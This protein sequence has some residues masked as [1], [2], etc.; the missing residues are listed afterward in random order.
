MS[1]SI[2]HITCPHCGK[3]IAMRV[4]RAL[5]KGRDWESVDWSRPTTEIARK[6]RSSV[7]TVS[8]MR[9][10]YAPETMERR[11]PT[12]T[13][14]WAAV[15]WRRPTA[16]LAASLRMADSYVSTMRRRYAPETVRPQARV[17]LY[18]DVDWERPLKVIAAELGITK[19]GAYLA[20]QRVRKYRE[21]QKR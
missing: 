15:D 3:R 13:V 14:D 2:G 8:Q 12:A 19:Q 9:N 10:R 17:P 11:K 1:K 20:R 21:A 16:D 6:M 7:S 4:G 18:L 5:E